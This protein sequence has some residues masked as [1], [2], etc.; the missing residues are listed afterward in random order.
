MFISGVKVWPLNVMFAFGDSLGGIDGEGICLLNLEVGGCTFGAPFFSGAV[1]A[2]DDESGVLALAQGA[3]S[4]E[5][6]VDSSSLK[7]FGKGE[8]FDYV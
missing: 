5:A 2:V 8:T 1:V 6:E 4:R 7:I 3:V